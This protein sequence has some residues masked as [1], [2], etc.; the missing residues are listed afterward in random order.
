MNPVVH[1]ELHTTDKRR[2]SELYSSLLGWR[3]EEIHAGASS[4]TA[5]ALGDRCGGGV[6]ETPAGGEIAFWQPKERR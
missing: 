4:Y 2:A 3:S 6:V 1:L 5:L